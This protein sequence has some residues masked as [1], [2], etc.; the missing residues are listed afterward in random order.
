MMDWYL[1]YLLYETTGK[2]ARGTVFDSIKPIQGDTAKGRK[3]TSRTR[4]NSLLKLGEITICISV[5]LLTTHLS[6]LIKYLFMSLIQTM[7]AA[8]ATVLLVVVY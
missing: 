2:R 5:P 6:R 1:N 3:R 8:T 7:V 4:V